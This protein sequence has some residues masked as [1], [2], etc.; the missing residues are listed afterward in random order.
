[1]KLCVVCGT[2][3]EGSHK[4]QNCSKKCR[5]VFIRRS[6]ALRR[7]VPEERIRPDGTVIPAEG[8]CGFCG[9][10]FIR[11]RGKRLFCSFACYEGWHQGGVVREAK[12]QSQL[13]PRKCTECLTEFTPTHGKS[14]LCSSKCRQRRSH[15]LAGIKRFILSLGGIQWPKILCGS[16]ALSVRGTSAPRG[17]KR[18]SAAK[19]VIGVTI[20]V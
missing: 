3:F 8:T 11:E 12:R 15:R 19:P 18:R 5:L 16:S 9:K 7:G 20:S 14:H 2:P 10:T 4:A 13:S 1:M 17:Q 6:A